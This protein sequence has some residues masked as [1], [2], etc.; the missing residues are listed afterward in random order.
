LSA[1]LLPPR[2]TPESAL[3]GRSR[4]SNVQK[5]DSPSAPR[6]PRPKVPSTDHRQQGPFGLFGHHLFHQLLAL[7]RH[8]VDA[9]RAAGLRGGRAGTEI[10]Q[11][12][13]L[14]LRG[15]HVLDLHREV[16]HL[17]EPRR[18]S[19]DVADAL[20]VEIAYRPAPLHAGV[21][22]AVRVDGDAGR[23]GAAVLVKRS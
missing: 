9:Q 5:S 16:A 21:D 18:T 2:A 19:P 20:L 22:V 3:R 10:E 11:V 23:A 13:A 12:R 7:R 15:D 14:A 6:T 1:L 4:P 8:R 17:G